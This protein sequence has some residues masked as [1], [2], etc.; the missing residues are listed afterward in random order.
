MQK[1]E[2]DVTFDVEQNII[3]YNYN[4]HKLFLGKFFHVSA[5]DKFFKKYKLKSQ[6]LRGFFN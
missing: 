4:T 3:T 1:K 6:N 5:S 2:I